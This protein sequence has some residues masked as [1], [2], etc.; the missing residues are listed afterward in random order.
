MAAGGITAYGAMAPRSQLFGATFYRGSNA[1]QIALTYD[2]GP[3]NKETLHLLDVLAKHSAKA[4]FFAVGK[5]VKSE[6]E[7]AREIVAQGH[8]LANHTWSHP[9]LFWISPKKVHE[10]LESCQKEIADATGKQA[11][12][13]RPPFGARRPDVLGT[14]RVLGLTTVMWT[15]TCYDWKATDAET[16]AAYAG[17]DIEKGLFSSVVLLHDGGHLAMGADR[18]HSVRATELLLKKY[19]PLGYEFVTVDQMTR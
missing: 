4:T 6:P 10:E 9:N 17:V 18:S 1:R 11:T 19:K 3:N 7:I 12:L 16:V 14:A 2:D 5:Y 8:A 13:F 15:A